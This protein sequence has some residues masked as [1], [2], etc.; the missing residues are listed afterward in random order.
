MNCLYGKF[1]MTDI[2]DKHSII[3]KSDLYKIWD[4]ANNII[5]ETIDL[6]NDKFLISYNNKN[7]IYNNTI[8]SHKSYV[9]ISI[10]VA[11]SITF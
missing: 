10:A 3:S 4:E 11:A 7:Q 5:H 2:L 8:N 6:E 9:N 1:G